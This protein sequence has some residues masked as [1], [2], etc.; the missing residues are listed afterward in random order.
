MITKSDIRDIMGEYSPR[1]E[2]LA[3]V[4]KFIAIGLDDPFHV[5]TI[6]GGAL[7]IAGE[8]MRRRTPL[9]VRMATLMIRQGIQEFHKISLEIST[10]GLK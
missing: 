4:G 2:T 10:L 3:N 5:T 9:G 7:I 8:I 1:G 6:T